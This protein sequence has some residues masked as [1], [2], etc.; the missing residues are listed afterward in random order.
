[1][2][3]L[4]ADVAAAVAAGRGPTAG[5]LSLLARVNDLVRLGM[6]ADQ[7]RRRRHGATATFVRVA[8]VSPLEASTASWPTAA[9]EVR[10]TGAPEDAAAAVDV[11][12]RLVAR[13]GG[14]A[15]SAWSLHDLERISGSEAAL[16]DLLARLVDAGVSAIAEAPIDRL[17]APERTMAAVCRA[18][19]VIGRVTAHDA[20]T[21]DQLVQRLLMVRAVQRATGTVRVFAPLS[22][23][24]DP[25]AP[26]TGFEDSKAIALARLALE[27]VESIQVDWQL[28]GPKLAQVALLFGADDVDAVSPLEEIALGRRRAPLEEIRRNIVAASLTPVERNG[29]WGIVAA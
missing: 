19:G 9:G 12:R 25:Q 2:D 3:D 26:T 18:G 17:A 10:L 22:R 21:G 15:V 5:Q 24:V 7:A 4:L 8:E 13:S 29:R 23:R 1:M 27:N 16:T 20:A 6:L 11:A 28:Y 14:A